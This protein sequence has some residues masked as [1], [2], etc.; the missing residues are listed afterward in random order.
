MTDL[1]LQSLHDL[2]GLVI[3]SLVQFGEVK[4]NLY[5]TSVS[6]DE[7]LLYARI[8]AVEDLLEG[9]TYILEHIEHGTIDPVAF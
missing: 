2:Q 9:L 6:L 4:T 3:E 1:E 5:A 7:D 8:S